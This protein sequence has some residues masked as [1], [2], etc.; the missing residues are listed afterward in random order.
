MTG[1][2]YSHGTKTYRL[3]QVFPS[4]DFNFKQTSMNHVRIVSRPISIES[5]G[6]QALLPDFAMLCSDSAR[7]H[8]TKETLIT[9]YIH[10]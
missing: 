8:T 6:A 9:Q 1:F 7:E 3:G 2:V 4:Y 10:S 5:C